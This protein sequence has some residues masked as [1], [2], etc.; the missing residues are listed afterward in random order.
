MQIN[1]HNGRICI[2]N[3]Y[4]ENLQELPEKE[5]IMIKKVIVT[6]IVCENVTKVSS[7]GVT[8]VEKST[9]DPKSRSRT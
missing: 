2:V 8:A 5:E 3:I 7:K 1:N 4:R 9:S 6:E